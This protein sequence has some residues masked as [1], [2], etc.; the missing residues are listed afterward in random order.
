MPA[1]KAYL[2]TCGQ[3]DPVALLQALSREGQPADRR[4]SARYCKGRRQGT[5]GAG[6][7]CHKGRDILLRRREGTCALQ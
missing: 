6:T 4:P 3:D 1:V 2:K 7:Y 5:Q